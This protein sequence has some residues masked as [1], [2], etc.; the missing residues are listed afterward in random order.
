MKERARRHRYRLPVRFAISG[1]PERIGFTKDISTS[2]AFVLVQNPPPVGT[3][4]T[5]KL[6]VHGGLSY[7][8]TGVV[9]RGVLLPP[10]FRS[11]YPSGFGVRFLQ[12]GARLL[13][14]AGTGTALVQAAR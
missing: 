9:T 13:E 11:L 10:E 1:G 3:Q 12:S 7:E 2:G 8:L 6:S 14:L 5:L 4:L